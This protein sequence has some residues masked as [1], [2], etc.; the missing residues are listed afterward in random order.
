MNIII[1]LLISTVSVMIVAWL[2]PGVHVDS[3]TTALI[4]AAVIGVLNIFLKPLLVIFT[5]PIT[6]I[7][8]G[9]FLLVINT[10]III[11]ASN[12]VDGFFVDGFWWAF[13]FS[14]LL[15][16]ISSLLGIN[17]NRSSD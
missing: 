8:L 4:V 15:S 10:I 6:I 1:K 2:L 7:T 5:I 3:I 12:L 16:F 11:I 14:I 13:F 9:F 17:K